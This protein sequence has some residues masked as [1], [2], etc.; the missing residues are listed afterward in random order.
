MGGQALLYRHTDYI[1][2]LIYLINIDD[3]NQPQCKRHIVVPVKVLMHLADRHAKSS[4]AAIGDVCA[5]AYILLKQGP[6]WT[7]SSVAT[8]I[9]NRNALS[10]S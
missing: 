9:L 6:E 4:L 1:H 7:A 8:R 2:D 5:R 3:R 10:I